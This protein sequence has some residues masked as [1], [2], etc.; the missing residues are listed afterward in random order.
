MSFP[1]ISAIAAAVLIVMQMGLMLSVGLHRV[2]AG[3]NIGYGEDQNL[4]R[5]IRRH[6]NLAENSALF[7][8]A[9]ALAELVGA[10]TFYLTILAAL[11]VFARASHAVALSSLSGSHK[12]AGP[13]FPALRALGAFGTVG[14]GIGVAVVLLM[15]VLQ[16]P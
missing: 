12:P 7:L 11:F 2:G 6:G 8:I 10:P 16:T 1:E 13:I 9:L 4:E 15:T 3:I 14:S 5:K